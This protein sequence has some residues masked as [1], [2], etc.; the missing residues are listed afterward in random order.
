MWMEACPV[1]VEHYQKAERAKLGLIGHPDQQSN[2][3]HDHK[4]GILI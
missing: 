4:K 1:L 3:R 2:Y